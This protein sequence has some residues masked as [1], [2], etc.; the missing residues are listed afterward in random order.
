MKK[1]LLNI[2]ASA[3]FMALFISSYG[4][5]TAPV[6][7]IV[8]PFTSAA[9]TLDG[10]DDEAAYQADALVS[11]EFQFTAGGTE[12]AGDAADLSAT[13]KVCYDL[14]YLY[15]WCNVVDD[16]Q[17][18]WNTANKNDSWNYDNSEIFVNLDTNYYQ[19]PFSAIASDSTNVQWRVIRGF[20]STMTG[21]DHGPW[22]Q[23]PAVDESRKG[24]M[25]DVADAGYTYEFKLSWL[26]N[27]PVGSVI[28]DFVQY[29]AAG[30]TNGFEVSWGDADLNDLGAH[31]GRSRQA[32]WDMD[33]SANSDNAGSE[34]AAY[35]NRLSLGLM[36]F[37]PPSAIKQTTT[38]NL[39]VYPNP[40]SGVVTI[41]DMNGANSVQVMNLAGQTVLNVLN[42]NV[43]DMSSLENGIYLLKAGTSTAVMT[44]MK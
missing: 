22:F 1:Q 33:G 36:T 42:S 26:G 15:V 18:N 6:E 4:Q 23:L 38:N 14:N 8:I 9:I 35:Q 25:G 29:T 16:S 39:G 40:T 3:A 21:A 20:D 2:F 27:M 30:I 19:T 44:L 12:V 43:I 11:T 31:T 10:V 7:T 28:G 5:Q 13:F 32:T 37:A 34:G 41:N 17:D 24:F